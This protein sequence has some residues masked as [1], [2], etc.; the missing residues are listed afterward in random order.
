MGEA[1]QGGE[2]KGRSG[3]GQKEV[4]VWG[5]GHPNPRPQACVGGAKGAE[6]LREK[7]GVERGCL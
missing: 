6:R 1:C 3:C 2:G 4:A 7:E 5:E